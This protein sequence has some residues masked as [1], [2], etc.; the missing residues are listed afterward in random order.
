MKICCGYDLMDERRSIHVYPKVIHK[1][2][3]VSKIFFSLPI[4]KSSSLHTG[5]GFEKTTTK[6]KK[7]PYL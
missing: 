4:E 3:Y 2:V 5:G 1:I 7:E 6:T